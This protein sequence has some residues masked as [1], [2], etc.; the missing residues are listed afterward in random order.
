MSPEPVTRCGVRAGSYHDSIVLMRLQRALAAL[1]G[2]IDAGVIMATPGNREQLAAGGFDVEAAANPDD[3]LVAVKAES[4]SLAAEALSRIDALL[5]VRAADSS[6]DYRPHSLAAAFKQLPEARWVL[7]SVPGRYAADVAGEALEQGRN[8][9]LYSDNVP[10]EREVELKRR[11]RDKG[12]LV[13]GPD[14]GTASLGGVGFGFANRARRGNIGLVGASGTGLQAIMSRIHAL[15]S[16]ISQAIGTGGRDLSA[17]VGGITAGQALD[18]LRRDPETDVIVLIAKPPDPE[19]GSRLLAQARATGKPVVVHFLGAPLPGRRLGN[20]SFAAT[21][22]EAAELAVG[23]HP[24]APSPAPPFTPSPGEGKTCGSVRGLFSGG[25]L[26]YEAL[27]GLSAFLAPVWSN[28][29]KY[30]LDDLLRSREHTILDLGADEFTV[31]RLH[32]MIDQDLRLRRLRQEAAD[33]EVGLIL[34]DVVLGEGSH[35]DP[36]GELAP[37]IAHIRASRDVE[38]AV[39]VI[40]TDADPQGLE[41]QIST[42][43]TAGA[44]VFRTVTDAVEWIFLNRTEAPETAPVPLEAVQAPVAAINVG[45]ESFHDSLRS[46]GAASVHVDWRPPAGGNE[47]LAGILARMKA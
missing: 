37:E 9:F 14:C 22:S 44:R 3:L 33:P 40:G 4:E 35:A 1:P 18:L 20:V 24:P 28:L 41:T 38:V 47:R 45:L 16:G 5:R 36:A 8:V 29:G 12:L 27:L 46:Q 23:P 15:D 11:A 19:V 2:V 34:L 31:G 43:E 7:V 30:R 26:A 6:E 39:V 17:E 10:V 21:L 32:P 25:T 13:L 42:L